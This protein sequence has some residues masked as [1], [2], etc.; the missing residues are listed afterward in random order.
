MV[1]LVLSRRISIRFDATGKEDLPARA[2]PDMPCVPYLVIGRKRVHFDLSGGSD[3]RQMNHIFN[4]ARV[5]GMKFEAPV[6][7]RL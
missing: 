3:K 1:W 5:R 4:R 2:T 7:M 6:L